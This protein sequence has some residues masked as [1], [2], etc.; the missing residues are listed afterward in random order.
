MRARALLIGVAALFLATGTAR[1]SNVNNFQCGK[2][3]VTLTLVKASYNDHGEYNEVTIE[4][5]NFQKSSGR[6]LF[7]KY[8]WPTYYVLGHRKYKCE[9]L[10]NA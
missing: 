9:V 8:G 4:R 3:R 1:T 7:D 10:P 2:T 6:L 5:K